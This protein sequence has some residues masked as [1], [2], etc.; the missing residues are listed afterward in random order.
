[1]RSLFVPGATFWRPKIDSDFSSIFEPK[2]AP[3]ELILAP[4]WDPKWL[5]NQ[6]KIEVEI[7]ST[8]TWSQ[9]S[10]VRKGRSPRTPEKPLIV[11]N[12]SS[13]ILS[14]ETTRL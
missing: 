1:M 6:F 5:K 9:D 13:L 14:S 7:L 3:N 10:P 4:F 12:L 2:S 8:K 11:M